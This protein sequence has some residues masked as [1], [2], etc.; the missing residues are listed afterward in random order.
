MTLGVIRAISSKQVFTVLVAL[1]LATALLQ[2]C[3]SS[4]ASSSEAVGGSLVG[5]GTSADAAIGVTAQNMDDIDFSYSDRDLD[6]SYDASTATSIKL[7]QSSSSI[8]GTGVSVDGDT[9]TIE[10]EGTYIISGALTDGSIIVD[11][12]PE[13]KV[14]LVFD[15]VMVTNANGPAILIEQAEKVF[16]TLAD[17]SENA[18]SDSSE[19]SDLTSDE[20]STD[21]ADG[22]ASHDAALFSHDDL[23]ING[24]GAL[25]VNGN[26]AHAIVS[27]DNLVITGGQLTLRAV[28][29]TLQGKDCVK[30]KAGNLDLVA[31][32]DA[33][34]STATDDGTVG[35]VAMDGGEVIIN[36]KGDAIHA[37]SAL[38]VSGGIVDVNSSNEGLE[39]AW[40]LFQGGEYR[41][42]SSDDGVNAASD[43]L[44]N[45]YV[46]ISGGYLCIDAQGD[47]IDSNGTLSQTGGTV[48]VSGP[49]NDGN[50]A[51]DYMGSASIDGGT[52]LAV[53]SAG[54]AQNVGGDGSSQA[55]I[56][57]TPQS[58]IVA[59]TAITLSD[60]QG[61]VLFSF[62]AG[63]DYRSLV[64]S[65]A[66][67]VVGE[68]YAFYRDGDVS[69]AES[70]SEDGFSTGGMLGG[71]T[72]LTQFTLSFAASSVSAD[73]QVIE[74]TQGGMGFGGGGIGAPEGLGGNMRQQN[75]ATP[76]QDRQAPGDLGV[77]VDMTT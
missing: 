50:G 49:T 53:G 34:T 66:N 5:S 9:I 13:A 44:D 72:L 55:S 67:L 48:L 27:K 41:I 14:Q 11:S 37:E 4:T 12:D 6:A 32:D 10:T 51:L 1:T 38:R 2:G 28:S 40:V 69:N 64:F 46:I 62:V 19:R 58:T 16:I 8:A 65:S 15:G 56:I 47:G 17:G 25:T 30:I 59:G 20:V 63:K 31:G 24:N 18:L 33:I 74:S 35:F 57:Y 75:P 61:S 3:V 23:T 45:L 71:G 54:M 73:G 26:A 22:H 60:A 77:A 76:P 39:A 7:A 36:A 68:D 43:H 21:D 52:M 42:T 29:D 70:T